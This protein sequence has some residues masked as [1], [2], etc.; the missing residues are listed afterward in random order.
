MVSKVFSI[1]PATAAPIWVVI[2][3]VI[4]LIILASFFGFVSYSARNLKFILTE[5]GL[6]IKG[7]I[8]GRFI[9]KDSFIKENAKILNLN[10]MKEYKPK[11]RKNGIGLPGYKEGWF[12]LKNGEKALLYVTDSSKVAYIP[13][14]DS[15]SVLLSTG[16][17]KELFKSMNELWKD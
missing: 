5:Q 6:Q 10:T 14:K 11:I 3:I 13:T 2:A 12:K 8:Y 15:Y 17:P 9:P 16:Q 1:I 4:L 7:G